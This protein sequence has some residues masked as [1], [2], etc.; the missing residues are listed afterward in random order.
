MAQVRITNEKILSDEHYVLKR[1]DFDIQNKKGEWKSQ[2]REVFSQGNAVTVLLYNPAEKT[3]LLAQQFR[4][5]T[6]VNGNSSGMLIE[7]PAGMLEKDERP[8]DAIVRE[9][10]EETG[11]EVSKVEKVLEAY[12]SAG[13]LTEKIYYYIAAYSKDQKVSEGG[14][15][16]EEGEELDVMEIP[17]AQALKMI[18]S[19]EI[20]DAKTIIL[21]QYA[22]L[23]GLVS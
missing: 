18:E 10:K 22:A 15:L 20:Q 19:R 2:K 5:P 16:E 17:F 14:G 12:S 6:Y 9:I 7:V 13:S 21:L 3:V 23:K 1:I 11:Y 8:E 4:M